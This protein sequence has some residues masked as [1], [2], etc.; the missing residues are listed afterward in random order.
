MAY[1]GIGAINQLIYQSQPPSVHIYCGKTG[2][3]EVWKCYWI[4]S[5]RDY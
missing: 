5:N 3:L 2:V 1:V 4:N